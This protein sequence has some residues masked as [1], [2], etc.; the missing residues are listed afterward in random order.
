QAQGMFES[1]QS[2][3]PTTPTAIMENIT[4][5]ATN[6]LAQT[7][8]ASML[9]G[10]NASTACATARNLLAGNQLTE[11]QRPNWLATVATCAALEAAQASTSGADSTQQA[12]TNSALGLSLQLLPPQLATTNPTLVDALNA[13]QNGQTYEASASAH[14]LTGA[15]LAAYPALLNP[16]S[17]QTTLATLPDVT[18]RRLRQT[19]T[20]PLPLRAAA[21]QALVAQTNWLPDGLAF[22]KLVESDDVLSE[23]SELSTSPTRRSSARLPKGGDAGAKAGSESE[24]GP[25]PTATTTPAATLAWAGQA[26]ANALLKTSPTVIA[27]HLATTIATAALLMGDVPTATKWLSDDVLS[28]RS[29]LSTSPTRRSSPRA[30]RDGGAKAGSEGEGGE[31]PQ[32]Q[33]PTL[34]IALHIAQNQPIEE[35]DWLRW[36]TLQPLGTAAVAQHAQRT[37]LVAEAL[38]QNIPLTVWDNFRQRTL[39]QPT[40]DN[41]AWQRLIAAAA[42]MA[43]GTRAPPRSIAAAA[44]WAGEDVPVLRSR[45]LAMLAECLA[46]A[47]DARGA[48]AALRRIDAGLVRGDAGRGALGAE[49]AYAAAI[50]GYAAG[51]VSAGDADLER[52]VGLAASRSPRLFQTAVLTELVAGGASGITERQADDLFGTLLAGPSGRDFAAWPL[53][54]LTV[55]SAARSEA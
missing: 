18:L 1:A 27:P 44:E 29:E 7:W 9:L 26:S 19:T 13:L 16:E 40:P 41:P 8:A 51:R 30:E 43:A 11:A 53:E 52:A 15:V 36:L 25:Q 50:N 42:H 47:G 2:L 38:G 45:L 48:T 17:L 54:S 28:E 23:R 10:G 3:L 37:L 46:V 4:E 5:P 32:P 33:Q 55:A 14:P 35:A 49:A 20:L 31:R 22:V 24:G 34:R 6:R 39:G 12:R 21:A